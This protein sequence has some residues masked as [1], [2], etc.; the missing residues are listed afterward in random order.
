MN[1]TLKNVT[2]ILI[3]IVVWA[4]SRFM[5]KDNIGAEV[6]NQITSLCQISECNEII[7]KEFEN[8]FNEGF[9]IIG[10]P[11]KAKLLHSCIMKNN[12]KYLEYNE[13]F[14]K[15]SHNEFIL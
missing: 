15:A 13:A 5:Q 9:K 2:I 3:I 14:I 1:K 6:K 12:N 11:I 4:G 8:C 7:A 10:L